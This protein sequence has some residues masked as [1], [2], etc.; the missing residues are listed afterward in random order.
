VLERAALAET[1]CWAA[2]LPG[3]L[4]AEHARLVVLRRLLAVYDGGVMLKAASVAGS[5]ITAEAMIADAPKKETA[6]AMPGGGG[7]GGMDYS[8]FRCTYV[9]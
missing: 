7:M 1:R 5:L 4:A 8:A 9:H 6:P 3:L 2:V